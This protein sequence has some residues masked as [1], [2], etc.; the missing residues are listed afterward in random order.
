MK[1]PWGSLGVLGG[2][3]GVQKGQGGPGGNRGIQGRF[4]SGP[5]G[6]L[7]KSHFL[8]FEE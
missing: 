2:P 5:E 4:W 8:L 7:G 6:S 1:G 3:L